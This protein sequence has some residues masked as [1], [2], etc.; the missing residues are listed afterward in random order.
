MELT[1]NRNGECEFPY[2]RDT[3]F[4]AICKAIPT[5]GGF[6]LDTADK[7]SGRITVKAGI[8]AWSWGENIP[9]QLTSTS[10]FITKMQ[11]TSAHKVLVGVFDMGKNRKNV[12]QIISAT[13]DILSK[14]PPEVEQTSTSTNSI[15][16][17]I[18]KLKNL[19]D[20]GVLTLNEFNQQKAKLL[21]Q[22]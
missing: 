13:S 7:L 14:L 8:S 9:I 3:V 19:L 11:I 10:N 17:E 12:E 2:K 5:I 21:N 1:I 20:S 6:K 15:A 16:D 18:Q 4:E 22:S